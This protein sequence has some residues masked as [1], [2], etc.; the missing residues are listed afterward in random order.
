VLDKDIIYR[1]SGPGM[2]ALATRQATLAARERPLL[3]LVDGKRSYA[4]LAV[5]GRAFGDTE[6]LMASLLAKGFIE[7]TGVRVKGQP[8][9]PVQAAPAAAAP[10]S[11]PGPTQ[12]LVPLEQAQTFATERLADLLGPAG[13]D[14][15]RRIRSTRSA[16]EFRAAVRRTETALREVVGPQLAAEFVRAVENLRARA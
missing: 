7:S 11:A 2:D 10:P 16:H 13:D 4:E 14:L 5:L 12:L 1:K 3:I 6:D 8:P 9:I 15:C